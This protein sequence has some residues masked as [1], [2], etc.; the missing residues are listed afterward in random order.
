MNASDEINALLNYSYALLE[1]I[2][3]KYMNAVCLD[4]SIGFLHEIAK[5]KTPLIYDIQE[6]FGW[7]YDIS[8]IELL[9]D[10]KLKKSLFITTEN[11]HIRLKPETARLLIEKFRLNINKKYPYKGKLYA[12]ETIILETLKKLAN[13]ISGKANSFY[14][15]IP[16]FML[17]YMES[18]IQ[19]KIINMTP[20]ERKARK[21]NKS[22]LW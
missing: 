19:E 1:S 2:I 21:I 4:S 18:D 8:V 7:A 9:V 14:P 22:T 15:D 5:S 13:F 12:L 16:E 6:L 20:E 11:Y 3:R 17:E 10:K